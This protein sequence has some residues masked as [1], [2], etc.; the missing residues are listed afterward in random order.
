M[1]GRLLLTSLA[2]C[3]IAGCSTTVDELQSPIRLAPSEYVFPV[4]AGAGAGSSGTPGVE[5]AVLKGDPE[6][7]GLYTI[8]LRI[9]PG[10]RIAPHRHRDDRV[11][12]V[13]SGDWWI[14]FG[15]SFDEARLERLPAG[16]FYTE[17]PDVAHFAMTG[18]VPVVVA[19]TGFG[20]TDTRPVASIG[21]SED[22]TA[23]TQEVR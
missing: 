22:Q 4:E 18:S 19:I 15:E 12:T 11:A 21:N 17:P 3:L 10:T 1:I 7:S 8:L 14:G 6:R 23:S 9:A 20:P 13:I 5:T 16:S 2:A